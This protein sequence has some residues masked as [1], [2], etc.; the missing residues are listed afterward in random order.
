MLK[1]IIKTWFSE[2]FEIGLI[3]A[4]LKTNF[5]IFSPFFEEN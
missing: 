5:L 2:L 3:L 1:K 4:V